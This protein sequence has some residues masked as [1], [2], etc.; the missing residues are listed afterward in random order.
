MACKHDTCKEHDKEANDLKEQEI[1]NTKERKLKEKIPYIIAVIIFLITF[2]PFVPENVKIGMYIVTLLLAGYEL[3]IE[4]IKNIFRLRF[5]EDT[6]MT[7]AVVAA[8]FLGEFREACLVV[9]LFCLGEFIEDIAVSKSNKNIEKIVSIKANTANRI[10]ENNKLESI[11]TIKNNTNDK[12][13][14]YNNLEDIEIVPVEELRVGNKILI[15]PGEMVPVDCK[16]L[17]GSSQLD[18]SRLTG[19]SEPKIV[20]AGQEILSGN[21]NLKGS[22]IAE[23]IREYKDSTT[24]QIIDLVYEA[25]NN[26]GK[27]EKFITK[28]SKIYTPTVMILALAIAIIPILLGL[29]S[30]T[31]ITRALVFLVASCPCSIVISI[32]LAFF[33]CVGVLSKKGLLVKGTKH[34]ENLAK[35]KT[36]CFDK[37]G[38]ITT[39][40]MT[41]DE[42][43][44]FDIAEDDKLTKNNEI[45]NT[46]EQQKLFFSY[47]YSL[48]NLSN[49]PIATSIE[50]EIQ[51]QGWKKEELLKEVLQ[52]EEIPG[53]GVKGIIDG[54]QILFGNKKILNSHHIICT[55][56][57]PANGIYLAIDGKLAGYIVLKEE[58]RKGLNELKDKLKK[59]G[60][61]KIAMLTGD[62]KEKAE[63]IAQKVGGIDVYA[64]LLPKEK[65]E[66]VEELKKQGKVIFVGDGI[67]DSPVLAAADFSISM[68]EGTEIASNTADS[69]LI[70]NQV[71]SI[72][73][74]IKIAKSSMGIVYF[75]ITFSLLLKLIVL[76]LGIVGYAPIWLAVF[77]D[78][79]VTLITVLN[80][81]RIYKK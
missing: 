66:K 53:H 13:G 80:S 19:E 11:E 10:L 36:I 8:C 69:I 30:K 5:E 44:I 47:I 20:N 38:T 32:P 62:E 40:K 50:K 71:A 81:I 63:K 57:L 29:D 58:V 60:I 54:K 7:I 24:S 3:F 15:K 59:I 55:E 75:N 78:V 65:L 49:H 9:L 64:G 67:N 27:T 6:L 26:K 52:E 22:I 28:F 31:W 14:Q 73:N 25:T 34:I 72:P 79:G 74:I 35:A 76:I 18:T 21:M 33:S 37:T 61:S 70:S 77:A 45:Q 56:D 46:K 4:G 16:I 42:I 1:G 2:I 68:G 48:E 12:K 41:I 39:G 51:K 23:V 17:S 43:K